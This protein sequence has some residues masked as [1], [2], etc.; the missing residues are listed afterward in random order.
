V[1]SKRSGYSSQKKGRLPFDKAFRGLI[2][3]VGAF[4]SQKAG[5]SAFPSALAKRKHLDRLMT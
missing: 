3:A 2:T 1:L 5:D 4:G